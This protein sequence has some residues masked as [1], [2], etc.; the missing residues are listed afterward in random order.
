MERVTI[1]TLVYNTKYDHVV[2]A[3]ESI[4]S[5]TYPNLEH[6]IINDDPNDNENWPLIKN[7]ILTNNLPSIIIEHKVNKG[8]CYNI[9]EVIRRSTG[10]YFCG[11][12]DDILLPNKIANQVEIFESDKRIGLLFAD[13]LYIN[14][15]NEIINGV[16][17]PN[18]SLVSNWSNND[19]KIQ[20]E[21][22][23]IIP[24]PTVLFRKSAVVELGYF[25]EQ[26]FI[27][28]SD[29]Y[30]RFSMSNWLILYAKNINAHYRISDNS[31]WR[32][33][34]YKTVV[35]YLQ[36]QIKHE[37]FKK[38]NNI[39]E[40]MWYFR[41]QSIQ[42]KIKVIFWLVKNQKLDIAI[43][44]LFLHITKNKEASKRLH[45]NLCYNKTI[46]R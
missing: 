23:N 20:L 11:C 28:D 1:F 25:D 27:E 10:K 15:E 16:Y 26:M 18:N 2:K 36:F 17:G 45:R 34:S 29:I 21:Q 4:F 39:I 41:K 42:D 33:M 31:M 13:A 35:G 14:S 8:I 24:G 40:Y 37:I 12:S 3:I 22:H 19:Y 6:I 43:I 44:Y 32:N 38:N 7:Y 30:Y 46:I 5:Q 9:N